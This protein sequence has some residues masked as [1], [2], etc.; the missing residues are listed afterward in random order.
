M[1]ESTGIQNVNFLC[2]F[3]L[4]DIIMPTFGRNSKSPTVAGTADRTGCQ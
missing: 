1:K 2:R 4:A 3:G